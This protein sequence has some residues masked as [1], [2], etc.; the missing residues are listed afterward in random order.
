MDGV[1][2]IDKPQG[3]TSHDVVVVARRALGEPRI[4]HAGTLDPMATGVLV[5]ACGR[6]TRLA[7]FLTASDKEYLAE[8]LFGVST[9]SYDV[10]GHETARTDAVP[11]RDAV[12]AAL[13]SLRGDYLQSPPPVSA[14][15]VDGRRAYALAR[16]GAPVQPTPVPVC[17]PT[18]DL[19]ALEG[20]VATV[21][22]RCSAGFYVRA[23]AHAAGQR[24]GAGAC[25]RALR[26]LRSGEFSLDDAVTVDV[27]VRSPDIVAARAI[28]VARLLPSM[29]AARLTPEGLE[30]VS[31]GRDIGPTHVAGAWP[32]TPP[33]VRLTTADGLLLALAVP[34][35]TPGLLHPSVVL[36]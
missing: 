17:V 16:A 5:L 27:L 7:A 14:K 13:E 19:L 23:L 18:M 1:L 11:S 33:W 9:D 15:K 25:L 21:R 4:G 26:R 2:V 34:G 24:T 10:T 35:T 3:L 22:L 28:P 12:I 31:H 6:A 36:S 29:P 30:R 20:P 8:I 32:G